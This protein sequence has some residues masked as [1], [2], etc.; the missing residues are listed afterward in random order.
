MTHQAHGVRQGDGGEVRLIR[1]KSSEG[2]HHARCRRRDEARAL[3]EH[4]EL[5][6][7]AGRVV[8]WMVKGSRAD[9]I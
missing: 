3:R 7:L 9:P 6:P 4:V 1:E 8:A 2:R 5:I